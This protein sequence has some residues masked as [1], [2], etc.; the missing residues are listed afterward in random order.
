M[1]LSPLLQFS[2]LPEKEATPAWDSVQVRITGGNFQSVPVERQ[3]RDPTGSQPG[4]TE[5]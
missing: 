1:G 4:I 3:K 5:S 2:I